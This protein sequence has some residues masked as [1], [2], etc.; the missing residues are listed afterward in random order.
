MRIAVIILCLIPSLCFAG[1][2]YEK[3]KNKEPYKV[4]L[5]F[6]G[7]FQKTVTLDY[8]KQELKN[9]LKLKQERQFQLDEANEKIAELQ[10][11]IKNLRDAGAK[12][13]QEW[14]EEE[15]LK[16]LNRLTPKDINW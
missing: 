11:T 9:W 7:E 3:S 8:V 4:D 15:T 14:D 16:K 10:S 2:S 5:K 12:Y 13:W 1:I 6:D